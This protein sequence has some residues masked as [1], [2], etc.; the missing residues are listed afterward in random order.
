MIKKNEPMKL[1]QIPKL[2]NGSNLTMQKKVNISNHHIYLPPGP[3]FTPKFE[4]DSTLAASSLE[5]STSPNKIAPENYSNHSA[6]DCLLQNDNK[7]NQ[8]D[9]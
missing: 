1:Q 5:T 8:V 4:E 2:E 6:K 9:L 7:L 3:D